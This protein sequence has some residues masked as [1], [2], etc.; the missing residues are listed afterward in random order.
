MT[1][2]LLVAVVTVFAAL[3]PGLAR[4][5][6]PFGV[7][8]THDRVTDPAVTHQ[9]AIYLRLLVVA[10]LLAAAGVVLIGG[11]FVWPSVL[12][13][14]DF[15][16][17]L[18]ANHAVR[19]AKRDGR[20]G[21]D[22][23]EGVTVDTSFRTDP[24]RLPWSH[25]VPAAVITVVT[26]VVG[27]VRYGGLPAELVRFTGFGVNPDGTEPV[28]W[29]RAFE[30]VLIQLGI[31]VLV[32]LVALAVLRAR[33]D[34]DAAR[35]R[36]SAR[37]YRVYLR[38]V[39]TMTFWLA[40]ALTLGLAVSALQVWHLVPA[41]TGWRV[42]A[43]VPLAVMVVVLVVWDRRVGSAG[44]RLP[45]RRTF[46]ISFV[47]VSFPYMLLAL[48]PS[49]EVTL[50]TV[51]FFGIAGAPLNPI[52]FTIAFERIPV[53]LRGRVLGTATAGAYSAIPLGMLAGGLLVETIGLGPTLLA[54][55]LCYLAVT[56]YG[57]V[58]PAFRAMDV[59]AEPP[60]PEPARA[61]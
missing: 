24:V 51:A 9:K 15:G 55:G 16:I 29:A 19:V 26:F 25:L 8:I 34:L 11:D 14:V 36:G 10:G 40:A 54:I 60:A 35:P 43:Y 56:S 1:A 31:V 48:T 59:P 37:R 41:G 46:V 6:L 50:A 13:V 49:L 28:T 5:T 53:A 2:L 7:R 17:Y 22:K 45:R 38:G 32:P 61:R 18:R 27:L 44:H 3:L 47:L 39:A 57:L 12:A 30:P 58:N 33:P 20:W 4:P 52:L 21:Q 23:R 42:A